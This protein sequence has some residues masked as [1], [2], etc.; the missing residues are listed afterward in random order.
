MTKPEADAEF[1]ISR[2]F[3]A[4]RDLV[5]KVYSELEHLAK[6]WGLAGFTWLGG[7]LDFRPGGRFHYGMTSPDGQE[8]WGK[9]EYREIKA[10]ERVV[11]I[12]AFSN[13]AGDTVRAPF[14]ADWPLEVLN[15]VTF[16]EAG[17][18]ATVTLR[19]GPFNATAAE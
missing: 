4:P 11:F 19:G 16:S 10:P 3:D 7:T 5:F 17:G 12:N 9:F 14:S 18:R 8:M 6:W 2:T 15:V 1:V 13:A